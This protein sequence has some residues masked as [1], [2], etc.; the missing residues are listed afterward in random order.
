MRRSDDREPPPDL[1]EIRRAADALLRKAG[2]YDTFPTPMTEIVQAAGLRLEDSLFTDE[3]FKR[4]MNAVDA[5]LIKRA[6]GKLLGVVDIPGNTI[7]VRPGV[8]WEDPSP[9][10][11]HETGHAYLPWQRDAYVYVQDS[12][13]YL[14]SDVKDSFEREATLFA[15]ELIFQV[16]RFQSDAEKGEFSLRTPVDLAKRYGATHYAAIRRFVETNRRPC[17]LVI[18]R[19]PYRKGTGRGLEPTLVQSESFAR[20]FGE[21]RWGDVSKQAEWAIALPDPLY[22]ARYR[23]DL[24]DCD[25]RQVECEAHSH[26]SGLHEF[27][28]IYLAKAISVIRL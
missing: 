17:A 11:L 22:G 6:K 10:V 5:D 24:L 12:G 9:L 28:F 7:Y 8:A 1:I 27:T 26:S 15:S 4:R 25:D 21:Q 23:L 19:L 13:A 20:R 3:V 14:E 16:D 18:R 2:A